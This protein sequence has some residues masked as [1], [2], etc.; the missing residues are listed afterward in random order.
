MRKGL[1][2]LVLTAFVAGGVFAQTQFSVGGG[3]IFDGGRLGAVNYR[4]SD[5]W[6]S[7]PGNIYTESESGFEGVSNFGFGGWFFLGTTH[8]ELSIALMGGPSLWGGERERTRSSPSGSESW[9]ERGWNGASFL[10]FDISL[11][12]KL[13]VTIGDGNVSVFP[14]LGIGYN[15]VLAQRS[16]DGD[17]VFEYSDDHS[18]INLSTFRIHFGFGGDFDIANNMFFRISILGNYRFA[19]SLIRDAANDWSSATGH[20]GGFGGSVRLGIGLRL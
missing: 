4:W 1:L 19:P 3:L 11:L 5:T 9:T 12:G 20:R 2:V 8:T 10:A 14:L 13:P 18:A 15:V 17:D 7:S 6:M 16:P